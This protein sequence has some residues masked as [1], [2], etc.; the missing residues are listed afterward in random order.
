MVSHNE[1]MFLALAGLMPLPS[2]KPLPRQCLFLRLGFL[3]AQGQHRVCVASVILLLLSVWFCRH[4]PVVILPAVLRYEWE[5][6][7]VR[8]LGVG[9]MAR[10]QGREV[11]S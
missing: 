5:S 2:P 10:E 3:Q 7:G 1:Q 11:R 8:G 9:L 4:W 6:M